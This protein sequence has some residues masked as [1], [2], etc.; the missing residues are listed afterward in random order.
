[1]SS[2]TAQAHISE[3]LRRWSLLIAAVA[4]VVVLATIGVG[5]ELARHENE[6]QILANLQARGQS[7]AGFVSTFLSEQAE[8]EG[9]TAREFLSG[10]RTS[11]TGFALVVSSFGSPA[12]VVLNRSGQLLQVAPRDPAILGSDIAPHYAHLQAAEAGHIAVSGVVRSAAHHQPVIAVAV[13]YPTRAGRRV[14]SVAYPVAQT[15]LAGLVKHA[16]VLTPHRVLLIDAHGMII[17][18]NPDPAASTL[19]QADPT[20]AAAIARAPRGKVQVAGFAARY[21]LT[22]VPGTSWRLII[23]INDGKLFATIGGL[24]EWLPWVVF[25]VL[26][27]FGLLALGLFARSVSTNRR[28]AVVSHQLSQA[29]LTDSV[30]GLLNRRG[31]EEHLAQAIAYAQ[32]SHEPLSAL[33]IDLDHFKQINDT[34]GHEAGDGVLRLVA[35]SMRTVFRESDIFGRWGGDEFLA[36]LPATDT[37]GADDAGQ[38]LRDHF[39]ASAAL[40]GQV[41]RLITLS[42]GAAT[43]D[44]AAG[45]ELLRQADLALYLAKRARATAV[46]ATG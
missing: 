11:P 42:V 32:R 31:L 3:A 9:Q 28:L 35:D 1:M 43:T 4:L 38:R 37:A 23:A 18:G 29:A 45:D 17:A 7:S 20:L 24:A 27:L 16:T 5:I 25:S 12:A 46:M 36:L 44:T 21:V 14:F 2:R 40:P 22:S 13:P 8:R 6:R 30:T 39:S 15:V 41:D 34:H 33:T 26:S 10:A 19:R